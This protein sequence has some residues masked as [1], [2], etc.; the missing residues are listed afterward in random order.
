MRR[1]MA[2]G[3]VSLCIPC[4]SVPCPVPCP[5]VRL[6]GRDS[7]IQMPD[8]QHNYVR[9]L[10]SPAFSPEAIASYLPQIVQLMQRHLG[11]WVAAGD[12]GVKGLD[13]FKLLTFEFIVQVSSQRPACLAA[14]RPAGL[15]F[16]LPARLVAGL[17]TCLLAWCPACPPA[18]LTDRQLC[19]RRVGRV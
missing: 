15:G 2:K 3:I 7:L 13:S 5:A 19:C 16:C 6:M 18:C 4:S 9:G 8:P 12:V 1:L 17:V 11:E 14:C 10:L